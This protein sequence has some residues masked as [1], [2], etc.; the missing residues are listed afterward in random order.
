MKPLFYFIM[1]FLGV[2]TCS[3]AQTTQQDESRVAF[4]SSF[5]QAQLTN[6]VEALRKMFVR[7]PEII[8]PSG[9][10]EMQI[11]KSDFYQLIKQAGQEQQK[12]DTFTEITVLTE[13]TFIAQINFVYDSYAF[14]NVL[15]AE[16]DGYTWKITQFKKIFLA[17]PT[18][19]VVMQ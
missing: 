16:K 13:N 2:A 12:C 5:T 7:N 6:N 10:G 3:S 14:Q 15:T 11:S 4:I 18:Q 19:I 8:I 1:L 9:T 17:A